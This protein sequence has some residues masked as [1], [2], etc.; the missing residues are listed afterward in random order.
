MRFCLAQ[1]QHSAITLLGSFVLYCTER[2]RRNPSATAEHQSRT[3]W[4]REYGTRT[5][6]SSHLISL[7]VYAY[8]YIAVKGGKGRKHSVPNHT[9]SKLRFS[10]SLRSVHQAQQ[11]SPASLTLTTVQGG[12]LNL[13]DV[14]VYNDQEIYNRKSQARASFERSWGKPVN[15]ISI[16]LLNKNDSEYGC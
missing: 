14:L 9:W 1:T 4:I 10:T 11:Y 15:L 5:D 3:S 6:L 8:S 12:I 16:I 2:S 13:L 7:S